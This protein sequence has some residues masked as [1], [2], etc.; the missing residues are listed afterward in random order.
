M[1]HAHQ[2]QHGTLHVL[3]PSAGWSILRPLCIR[4]FAP[5]RLDKFAAALGHQR[6][7][8]LQRS[9]SGS[10]GTCVEDA[11]A[12]EAVLTSLAFPCSCKIF[13]PSCCK[14]SIVCANMYDA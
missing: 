4:L 9:A 3:A 11:A 10:Y 14:T 12:D 6:R 2:S 1:P 5:Y 8:R 7:S 13:R